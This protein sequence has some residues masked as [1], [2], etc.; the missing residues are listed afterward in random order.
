MS[1]HECCS[2]RS[3]IMNIQSF[4]ISE[5][6]SKRV[7]TVVTHPHF[8]EKD[9]KR[10][11]STKTKCPQLHGPQMPFTTSTH[12]IHGLYC[13]PWHLVF[14]ALMSCCLVEGMDVD[15]WPL[16]YPLCMSTC[17]RCRIR[18]GGGVGE[19]PS[20]YI[21]LFLG[22]GAIVSPLASSYVRRSFVCE[23]VRG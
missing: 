21:P 6:C 4:N 12:T 2:K 18:G 8:F 9:C 23:G 16:F 10:S 11:P 20:G 13:L 7:Q 14:T 19:S 15:P 5:R 3:L 22:C 1:L 17:A